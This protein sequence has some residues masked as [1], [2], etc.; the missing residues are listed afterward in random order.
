MRDFRKILSLILAI[1]MMLS[2]G[3]S[4]MAIKPEADEE[5]T[6]NFVFSPD[7]DPKEYDI[8]LVGRYYDNEKGE[9]IKQEIRNGNKV[10]PGTRLE[11]NYDLRC[12]YYVD[13]EEI[14]YNY[15]DMPKKDITIY[16]TPKTY[17]SDIILAEEI[18]KKPEKWVT[19]TLKAGEGKFRKNGRIENG[20]QYVDEIKLYVNPLRKV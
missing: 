1:A 12:S 19:V 2:T 10:K 18:N 14:G 15:Y 20:P 13:G 11:G 16:V 6:V 7:I 17:G 5:Y 8:Y 3:I 4:I 9:F